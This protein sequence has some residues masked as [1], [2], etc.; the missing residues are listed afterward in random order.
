[1]KKINV[2]VLGATGCVG[3]EMLKVLA[4]R[5]FPV[6]QLRLLASARSAGRRIEFRG[7]E[8]TV[9]EADEASFAGMDLVLGAASNALAQ[10]FA[11]AIVPP[12]LP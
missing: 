5:E 10:R 2:A 7:R 1:M 12:S 6:G 9:E 4:E 11:P 3:R 8:Y